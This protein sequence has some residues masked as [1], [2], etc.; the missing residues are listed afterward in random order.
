MI[1]MPGRA[2]YGSAC[3]LQ[4]VSA[5]EGGALCER[6]VASAIGVSDRRGASQ[7]VGHFSYTALSELSRS[8]GRGRTSRDSCRHDSLDHGLVV[9]RTR[10]LVVHQSKDSAPP[11]WSPCSGCVR[12]HADKRGS[13]G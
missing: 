1:A 11:N 9:W 10:Q 6:A 12:E 8:Q 3:Y 13:K 4:S 2:E 7:G 5:A